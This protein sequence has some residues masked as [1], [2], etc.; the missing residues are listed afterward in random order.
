MFIHPF[1]KTLCI[2]PAVK[3]KTPHIKKKL[4]EPL[5]T[6]YIYVCSIARDVEGYMLAKRQ[7]TT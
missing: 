2:A 5:H 3:K 6:F 7:C 1:G 4:F